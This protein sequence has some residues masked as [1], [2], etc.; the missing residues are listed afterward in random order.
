VH[1]EAELLQVV[2]ATDAVGG[3]AH[4]LHGRQ[5]QADQDRDDRDHHQQFDQRKPVAN[6][7]T[8]FHDPL[9]RRKKMTGI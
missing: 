5:Q 7:P 9:L 4:L 2:G 8:I 3:L 6:S 1:G